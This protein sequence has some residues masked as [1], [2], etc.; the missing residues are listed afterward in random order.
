MNIELISYVLAQCRNIVLISEGCECDEISLTDIVNYSLECI[1]LF[2]CDRTALK[3]G[4]GRFWRKWLPVAGLSALG[5]R[6]SVDGT[7]CNGQRKE[8]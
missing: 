8:S 3:G 1:I 4:T 6:T 5:T 7:N 2:L